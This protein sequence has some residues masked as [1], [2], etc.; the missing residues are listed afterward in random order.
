MNKKKSILHVTVFPHPGS[1]SMNFILNNSGHKCDYLT[2]YP[3]FKLDNEFKKKKTII[4][5]S[6]F[7]TFVCTLYF[8]LY[9]YEKYN[10]IKKINSFIQKIAHTSINKIILRN[11]NNYDIF[12][13]QASLGKDCLPFLKNKI[14][15]LDKYSEHVLAGK[16]IS[17]KE[18]L[19]RNIKIPFAQFYSTNNYLMNQELNEYKLVDKIVVPS[20][21]SYRTF[22][23]EG[24]KSKD[25]HIV[26]MSGTF[27]KDFYPISY[28]KK[29]TF[30]VLYVGR[31]TLN[32]GIAYLVESFKEIK[33]KNKKLKMYGIMSQDGNEY[34][35][36]VDLSDDIEILS[37]V[38]FEDLKYIYSMSDVLV[39]PSLFDGFSNVVPQALT[40]GCPVIT[41]SNTGASDIVKNEI[42]GYVVPIMDSNAITISLNK[43]YQEKNKSTFDRG[44]IAKSVAKYKDWNKYASDYK[45]LIE[46]F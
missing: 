16:K 12:I 17:K 42:N 10:F 35:K 22:I 14:T 30:E 36:N 15:I 19:K 46:T 20:T 39:Q 5:K 37:T 6:L 9:R 44:H 45:E 25:L 43:I 8:F 18:Y 27:S 34:F 7:S 38:K 26:E 40:C 1:I 4:R 28:P 11:I 13:I 3:F 31:L 41:T 24:Y 33:I 29:E 32:K 2:M 23:D 21:F